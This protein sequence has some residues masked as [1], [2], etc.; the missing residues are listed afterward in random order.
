MP[1]TRAGSKKRRWRSIL[2]YVERKE[3][4]VQVR[5]LARRFGLAPSSV[6]RG[7]RQR[8]VR[9]SRF[10]W[11]TGDDPKRGAQVKKCL[12]ALA[13][14]F[15]GLSRGQ[16]ARLLQ[17]KPQTLRKYLLALIRAETETGKDGTQSGWTVRREAVRSLIEVLEETYGVGGDVEEAF[18]NVESK[19]CHYFA[20][21]ADFLRECV[22]QKPPAPFLLRKLRQ[23][24]GK[25]VRVHG[26]QMQVPGRKG[27]TVN[28]RVE[29]MLGRGRPDAFTGVAGDLFRYPSG[30][31]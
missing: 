5:H 20:T 26:L 25:K 12:R 16:V 18:F 2:K 31:S 6:S 10:P 19:E 8:R 4:Q 13:L 21:V 30:G 14:Y 9:L 17:M 27:E 15:L 22:A 11:E 3:G 1:S 28:V 29:S 23:I 24:L 7:L